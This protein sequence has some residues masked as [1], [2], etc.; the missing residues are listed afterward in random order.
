MAIS[1]NINLIL[2]AQDNISKTLGNVNKQI[3]QLSKNTAKGTKQTKTGFS[4]LEEGVK[5]LGMSFGKYLGPA[6]LVAGLVASVKQAMNAEVELNNLKS[7]VVTLGGSWADLE[8]PMKAYSDTLEEITLFSSGEVSNV[9][10]K[11]ITL[12]SDAENAWKNTGIVLDIASTGLMNTEGASK[13]VAMA[14]EGNIQ[15][16]GRFIP[17]LKGVN[18][19]VLANKT[20]AEKAAYAMQLLNDKFGGRAG[21]QVNTTAG[22]LAML[23][24]QLS[25]LQETIGTQLL[26]ELTEFFKTMTDVVKIIVFASQKAR[27]LT[28][29]FNDFY[30]QLPAVGKGIAKFLSGPIGI[31]IDI[32]NKLKEVVSVASKE[33]DKT[34]NT[35]EGATVSAKDYGLVTTAS[36]AM[37]TKQLKLESKEAEDLAKKKVQIRDNERKDMMVTSQYLAMTNSQKLA[38]EIIYYK[39]LEQELNKNTTTYLDIVGKRK[40]A[41]IKLAQESMTYSVVGWSKAY[42]EMNE[43]GMNYYELFNTMQK[44]LQESFA[45]TIDSWISGATSFSDFIG[46]IFRGVFDVWKQMLIDMVAE[47][48]AKGIMNMVSSVTGIG[49]GSSGSGGGKS[50]GGA[51]AGAGSGAAV[52]GAVAGPVGAVVGGVIGFIGGLFGLAEGGIVTKP[53]LAM[54]G[55]GGEPEAVIPLSKMNNMGQNI[56][57]EAGAFVINGVNFANEG[58]KKSVA[59]EIA[60]YIFDYP[61][62]TRPAYRR[63][64]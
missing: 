30:N 49:G 18:K 55:E 52:G 47:W 44:G 60:S 39:R 5:E 14:M 46:G 9:M 23:Q 13:A 20:Q 27:E 43:K 36:S 25:K 57:I 33:I 31:N 6:A 63:A 32:W 58:Q 51:L 34:K 19:E 24:K 7:A 54:V 42:N 2:T 17:E 59:Q 22:S 8:K 61:N 16:L 28:G 26:P 41:E 56:N 38:H 12:T 3:D 62:N 48:A 21:D 11:L 40:D 10:E 37:S 1:E 45:T 4:S 29:A 15:A 35:F 53:T 50:G 64:I